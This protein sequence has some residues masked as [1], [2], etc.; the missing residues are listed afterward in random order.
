MDM[1]RAK[2]MTGGEVM[3]TLGP[4]VAVVAPSPRSE[5]AAPVV[6]VPLALVPMSTVTATVP[7]EVP[8][9]I[10]TVWVEV[11][12]STVPPAEMTQVPHPAGAG[13]GVAKVSPAGSITLNPGSW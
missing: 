2:A 4:W 10:V 9:L 12:L 6:R 11:Q 3:V 7:S 5:S 13:A 1:A 8:A